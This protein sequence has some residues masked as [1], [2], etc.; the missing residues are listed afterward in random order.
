MQILLF[1]QIGKDEKA[2]IFNLIMFSHFIT[3][4]RTETYLLAVYK[5]TTVML[6]LS[7]YQ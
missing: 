3:V 4:L 1:K 2:Y 5:K 7:S 6:C